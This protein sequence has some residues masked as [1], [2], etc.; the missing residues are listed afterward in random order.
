VPPDLASIAER[1]LRP[2]PDDRYPSVEALARDLLA[3]RDGDRVQAH[4]YP[5]WE[6]IKRFAARNL[7]FSLAIG[8]ALLVLAGLAVNIWCLR[9][10]EWDRTAGAYPAAWIEHHPREA[11]WGYSLASGRTEYRF[12]VRQGPEQSALEEGEAEPGDSSEFRRPSG[13]FRSEE[14]GT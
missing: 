8:M 4:D 10:F 1:A 5:S 9:D 6:L 3:F 7:H 13:L 14:Y 12:F 2:S 11:R